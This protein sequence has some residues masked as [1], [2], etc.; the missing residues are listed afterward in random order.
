MTV[1]E[2][3]NENKNVINT[4]I[5]NGI[6]VDFLTDRNIDIYFKVDSYVKQGRTVSWACIELESETKISD[7]Q[8]LNIYNQ[9]KNEV[10]I[11]L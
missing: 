3:L 6:S 2:Y 1:A 8:I 11:S 9:Y 4:L 5:K 10:K 7:R